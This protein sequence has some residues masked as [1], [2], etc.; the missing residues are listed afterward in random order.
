MIFITNKRI[1][2]PL[3]VAGGFF[4]SAFAQPTALQVKELR[5]S[6]GMTVWL[7]EDHSQPKIS[8]SV[9]VRAG[10]KDCPDTGIAHYFEHIMF[11]GTDRIGTVD[12]EAERPWLDSISS[13]YDLLSQ[14]TDEVAR[15]AIQQ[16][17]NALS[18]K[19]GEYAIPNEFNRLIS[20]YGGTGLN[21]GTSADMT[22]YYNTFLPQYIEQWCWLNSE[23]L[24]HPVFRG[25][26]SELETVYEEKNR[27]ADGLH[28][29]YDAV[30]RAVFKD[31]PYAFPVLGST[32]N[33]KN[34]RLSD[35]E[36]FF[37]TYYVAP[38]M[39]LI[40]SGDLPA[41]SLTPLLEKTFGRIP[42]GTVPK[43][44]F[45]PIPPFQKGEQADIRLPIPIIKAEA[46]VFAAP[47]TFE[48]DAMA[49]QLANRLLSD[50][51]AGFLDSLTNEHRVMMAGAMQTS[52]NDAGATALFVVP[53]IPFGSIKKAEAL[54]LS[55]L[56]RL[57]EGDFSDEQLEI[58]RR[59]LLMEMEQ[60]LETIENRAELMTD[61]YS[62]GH[63]WQEYLDL[64][65]SLRHVT[66]ND[67][68]AAAKK[69]YG[70]QH[71]TL[72]KKYGTEKKETLSQPGY[73]PVQPKNAGA[74]SP[75]ALWLDSLPITD[76]SI[77]TVDFN[78]DVQ[79]IA[80]SEHVTL[81][82]VEN[83]V[84]DI[85]TFSLIYKNGTRAT[86]K[87][88]QLAAYL[89]TV[90][91]DSLTKQQL[92]TAWQH[93]GVTMTCRA[94]DEQFVFTLT[95]R[96]SQL[97][98]A[99]R[100]LHHFLG[101]AADDD[102]ALKELKQE[103]KV[104]DKAFGKQKDD[105]LLPMIRYI[106]LGQQSEYL[107]QLSLSEIKAL[108]CA[109]LLAQFRDV[110]QYDCDLVYVGRRPVQSIATLSQHLLLLSQCQKPRPDIHRVLLSPPAPSNLPQLGEALAAGSGAATSPSW[111]R[112]EGA[113]FFYHVP[114]SRQNFVCTY[115]QL[116]ALTDSTER[117]A[118]ELWARYMGGGMSSLLFQNIREFRS[119]AYST[120][121]VLF[122]PNY[123]RHADDP[124]AFVTITGTQ[125]D[126]TLQVF[127]A[128]DSLLSQPLFLTDKGKLSPIPS[129]PSPLS[130]SN[131]NL[132]AARQE[133]QSRIQN[134]FPSFREIGYYVA[135]RMMQGYTDDPNRQKAALLPRVTQADVQRYHD[136]HIT[137]NRRVWIVI[138]DRKLTDLQA[139]QRYGRVVELKKEDI[140]K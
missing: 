139:L 69:Y 125:A 66:K 111:G 137:S 90:G 11:K 23:R 42:T 58:Q 29:A 52:M 32:E 7:N 47:T 130:E 74:K 15:T 136:Q 3:I 1:L 82:S 65:E 127:D 122:E 33:L 43:R 39:C 38:N 20:K 115:E 17:I 37:R 105:V 79:R 89:G 92:E 95:G 64:I 99:L 110:Q 123:A 21:A 140:Y 6:N 78:N 59:N 70:A 73:T 96:D 61:V 30:M 63:S 112:Q 31:Q 57:M 12:Y 97:E 86:P 93:L 135:S 34:P 48:K 138:G 116:P 118:A 18:I 88:T 109:D 10:G 113:V 84:N 44:G 51:K 101:H 129:H 45:S 91:T 126:K 71:L 131:E 134:G 104:T 14:T 76:L 5:L 85:F 55:Q 87:L 67:V 56:N 49:L 41:D 81:F 50:E 54:C 77:C 94:D 8:G 83:P 80:L 72:R 103:A 117:T 119:L 26:Q 36:A 62:Q 102:K 100:L 106:S 40:L 9:V 108:N 13:Q 28:A 75:F 107:R 121:G 2:L 132:D 60:D 128:V 16:H 124:A 120:Q 98:P 24:I 22:M 27:A 68:V 133:M 19:A 46:L 25:F 4:F 114:K 53:K 35:M